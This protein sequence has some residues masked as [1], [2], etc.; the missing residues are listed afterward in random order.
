MSALS[1][2]HSLLAPNS[3]VKP[4]IT[5]ANAALNVCAK[6]NDMD[7]LW[8]I[9]ARLPH[10]GPGAANNYTFTTILNAMRQ[11]ALISKKETGDEGSKG[12]EAILQQGRTLWAD[13]I[14]RW[15]RGD[16]HIDE[17]LVCAM[18][19][20]LLIGERPRDWDDILSLV[21]QTMNIPRFSPR[22]GTISTPRMESPSLSG[23]ND[24]KDVGNVDDLFDDPPKTPMVRGAP[25]SQTTSS[26]VYAAPGRNTLSLIMSACLSIGQR[27][28]GSGY[29]ELL[30]DSRSYNVVPDQDNKHSYLRILRQARA[31][32]DAVD[33]VRVEMAETPALAKTY[34]IAM[35]TCLRSIGVARQD[36]VTAVKAANELFEIMKERLCDVDVTTLRQYVELLKTVD[37]ADIVPMVKGI[38]L[39]TGDK[40]SADRKFAEYEKLIREAH[41]S[42]ERTT[43]R[44]IL[45]NIIAILDRTIQRG[46][47][48]TLI[49]PYRSFKNNFNRLLAKLGE[50]DPV[51][52]APSDVRL[53]SAYRHKG[54]Q[55]IRSR[56]RHL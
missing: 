12:H 25:A 3:R 40:A 6:N 36:D 45:R 23:K 56:A 2:Y 21:Q 55:L 51:S 44:D 31:A 30:T 29:W 18:G 32:R 27:R 14:D 49:V 4:T 22:L 17:E 46:A 9:A 15:R 8:G 5:H 26:L 35:S 52:E 13:V 10:A 53:L 11:N 48:D 24:W 47:D 50:D 28:V 38:Q 34:R 39:L 16:L 1:I 37:S 41:S 54:P 43:I 33:F 20:L 19:R 42:E 7:A